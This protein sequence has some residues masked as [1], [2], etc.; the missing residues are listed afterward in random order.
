MFRECIATVKTLIISGN[1]IDMKNVSFFENTLPAPSAIVGTLVFYL[2]AVY[3][4]IKLLGDIIT[5]YCC[6]LC[7]I[8]GWTTEKR[9]AYFY[10]TFNLEKCWC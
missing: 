6:S 10:K 5:K 2:V 1:Y 7:L 4:K 9:I 3:P 8:I